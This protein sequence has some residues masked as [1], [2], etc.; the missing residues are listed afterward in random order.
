[1]INNL[2]L[3]FKALLRNCGPIYHSKG[4]HKEDPHSSKR[5]IFGGKISL[6]L[7][8]RASKM[9]QNWVGMHDIS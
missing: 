9:A 4:A 8:F 6:F 5:S 1:M 2:I 3:N 7:A